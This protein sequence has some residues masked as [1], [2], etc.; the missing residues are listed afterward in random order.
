M[1]ESP[2]IDAW[3]HL[4]QQPALAEPAWR[5]LLAAVDAPD[6]PTF[7]TQALASVAH[8]LSAEG[9]ALLVAQAGQWHTRATFG[10]APRYET[11]WL[12]DALDRDTLVRQGRTLVAPIRPQSTRGELIV[13]QATTVDAAARA[14]P[15]LATLA[16]HL[17]ALIDVVQ[18][19]HGEQRQAQRLRAILDETKHWY[20][21]QEMEPLLTRLA[22]AATRLL[23]ADRASIFL[24]DRPNH[25]L[26][27]RP[28]LG[29]EGNELRIADDVG[30]VGRVVRHGQS[31][32]VDLDSDAAQIDRR[33]DKQLGYQTRT[34]LGVPLRS[35]D[36]NVIGAFEAINKLQGNFTDDDEATLAELAEHAS[37]AL[38]NTQHMEALLAARRQITE[39]AALGVRF[40]GTSPVIEALRSTLGRVAGTDLAVLVLGENG[41]G[42]EVVAQSIHFQ[43]PRRDQP[44]IAVNCAAIPDTLLESELFGHERGA[45]TDA[46]E[47]RA[48]K[49][50]LARGGTLFLDEIGDLSLAGQAKLLRVVEEKVVVRVGGSKTIA[51]D[52]RLIAATNQDLAAMVREKRF[53]QD[54]FYRL[55]VVSLVLPPL[56]ERGADIVLLAEHFLR[57]FSLR[58]RRTP[59]RLTPAARQRLEGHAW[60][61][62]VREL[63]NLMERIAYLVPG[64]KIEPEDLAFIVGPTSEPATSILG[65][66]PLAE[67]TDQFQ[68][69]YIQQAM[70]RALGNMS[71]AAELLGLHRSN[72]YR[73]MRQLGMH[74]GE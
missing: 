51:T 13:L 50:E 2:L 12:G 35:S 1:L 63:R 71:Q 48:G 67:A 43:S 19:R 6:E 60:P 26:V 47:S 37:V 49:F 23:R 56:R 54:L 61:G 68:I 4:H 32:R 44:F 3:I 42:K 59:P 66:M 31:E 40:V 65:S 62:N 55:N 30:L 33:V 10:V 46:H 29:V 16:P 34:L 52:A 72:L 22:E 20:R 45:F 58:A 18:R 15:G 11:A 41:T 14:A 17:G 7:L 69:D 8:G 64:E 39:Q 70:R 28:A 38:Q 73:K 24:W 21:I 9:G 36:G 57:E 27:G 53:R 74:V 25:T 5:L